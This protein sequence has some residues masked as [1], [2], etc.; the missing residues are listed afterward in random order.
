[1]DQNVVVCL[2]EVESEAFRALSELKQA[3]GDKQSF[4]AQAVVVKKQNGVVTPL[5]RFDSGA[6]TG[7]DTVYGGIVG[8]LIGILGG[9]LGVL[10]GGS[11]GMLVGATVDSFEALGSACLIE[12]I[13]GKV[14][15]GYA[16]LVALAA[17]E[18]EAILDAKLNKFDVV[19]A[20][21]DAAAVATE[22]EQAQEMA[23]E[24]ARQA[25]ME[26]RK[27]KKA[28]FKEKVAEKQAK[29]AADCEEIWATYNK[30]QP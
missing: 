29:F 10:L 28:S 12:Q 4:V 30:E 5:D 1:M 19:I 23:A 2:F 24:M 18:D 8:S 20:R 22:V 25:R 26:L 7:N 11:Y 9:P 6:A 16:A 27:E 21:F 15:E 17:E 14:P 3:P 13:A